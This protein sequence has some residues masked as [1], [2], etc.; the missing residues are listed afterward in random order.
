[1]KRI[2]I[3]TLLF[4]ICLFLACGA[5]KNKHTVSFYE[6]PLVC[7]AAP[8]IGCG[9]RIKPLF[10]DVQK[11]K[12]IYQAWTNREG[13]IIAIK[14]SEAE[15]AT[16]EREAIIQ[17]LFDKHHIEAKLIDNSKQQ[18][19]LLLSM[20]QK[21]NN[22]LKGLAVDSLSHY[23]AGVIAA[24]LT[25]FAREADLISDAEQSRIKPEIEAYF[26]KELVK[27][28]SEEELRS[29]KCQDEWR[30]S[31]FAIYQKHIGKDRA[32][33]VRAYFNENEITIMKQESCCGNNETSCENKS[34]TLSDKSIITCPKCHHQQ[35]E[36]LPTEVCLIKYECKKCHAVLYPK[37]GD[38]C[39]FCTY[40][41][42]K[43]PSKQD[44]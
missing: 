23:E 35:E 3:S 1:M 2:K 16:H 39:V 13:T 38:C 40:G 7:G 8:E 30:M 17:S 6:V 34:A 10:L 22:W 29:Q 31:G 21:G 28:R 11:E 43:C 19:D 4:C 20:E 24:T 33:K 25:D 36:K 42:K 44:S 41:D 5:D 12:S 26:K 37:D 18:E 32:E 15:G 14:W 27:V 9:S